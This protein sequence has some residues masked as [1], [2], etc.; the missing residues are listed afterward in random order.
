MS[1]SPSFVGFTSRAAL[2]GARSREQRETSG[3][4]RKIARFISLDSWNSAGD[5]RQ[6]TVACPFAKV[7]RRFWVAGM[8]CVER[9]SRS[10]IRS[11][12]FP[13]P[14]IIAREVFPS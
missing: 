4:W 12:C 1:A 13:G 14:P 11:F 5:N 2:L 8:R 10:L 3:D 6:I 9:V 7:A